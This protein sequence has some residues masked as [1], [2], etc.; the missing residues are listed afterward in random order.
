MWFPPFHLPGP[1]L[2]WKI[3]KS[4][5]TPKKWPS[6]AIFSSDLLHGTAHHLSKFQANSWNPWSVRAVT[7]SLGPGPSLFRK[8]QS[9]VEQAKIGWAWP[10]FIAICSIVLCIIPQNFR[11]IAEIIKELEWERHSGWID[12]QMDRRTDDITNDNTCRADG[13]RG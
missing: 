12:G 3:Q 5:G 4:C 8:F 11:L 2:S 10:Y 9:S 6:I 13:S 7:S 1:N